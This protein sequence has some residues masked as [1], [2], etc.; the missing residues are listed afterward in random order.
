MGVK[1]NCFYVLFFVCTMIC[2]FLILS[3][4]D[5]R[6][7]AKSR[8]RYSPSTPKRYGFEVTTKEHHT[9][10]FLPNIKFHLLV[11]SLCKIPTKVFRNV[12]CVDE[13]I[14]ERKIR[15][16]KYFVK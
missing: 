1:I 8:S 5:D 3:V 11:V 12:K 10:K 13:S 15:R 14:S 2:V 4:Y 6:K 16:R 7:I 9:L